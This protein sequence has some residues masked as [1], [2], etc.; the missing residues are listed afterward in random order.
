MLHTS[1]KRGAYV[2]GGSV[3]QFQKSQVFSIDAYPQDRPRQLEG[4]SLW[5]TLQMRQLQKQSAL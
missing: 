2:R 4:V 5:R 3:C 1:P